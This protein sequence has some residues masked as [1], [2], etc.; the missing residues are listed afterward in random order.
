MC[1][2]V[3]RNVRYSINAKGFYFNVGCCIFRYYLFLYLCVDNRTT[4]TKEEMIALAIK[5]SKLDY[6]SEQIDCPRGVHNPGVFF[7]AMRA[8]RE[9]QLIEKEQFKKSIE[10]VIERHKD[11]FRRLKESGD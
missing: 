11:T 10:E 4:M 2:T 8:M 7:G 9:L 3:K 1:R 6:Q 5:V